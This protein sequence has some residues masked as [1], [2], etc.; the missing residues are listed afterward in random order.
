M[1]F[2]YTAGNRPATFKSIPAAA[3]RATIFLP[4]IPLRGSGRKRR[5]G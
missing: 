5:C 4:V 3:G 2:Q 1:A